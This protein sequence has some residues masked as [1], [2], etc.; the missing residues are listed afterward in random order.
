[1]LMVLEHLNYTNS[2]Q[3]QFKHFPTKEHEKTRRI[4]L[5]IIAKHLMQ[6]SSE[7]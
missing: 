1:M 2:F 3:T 7:L 5:S 6:G 4:I